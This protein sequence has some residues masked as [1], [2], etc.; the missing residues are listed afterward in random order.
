[1][2]INFPKD[3]SLIEISECAYMN[4]QYYKHYNPDEKVDPSEPNSFYE[5]ALAAIEKLLSSH[6]AY[7]EKRAEQYRLLISN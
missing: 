6:D 2:K 7:Y 5:I 4:I 1:M 3:W